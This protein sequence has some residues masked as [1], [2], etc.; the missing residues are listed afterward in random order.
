LVDMLE[1]GDVDAAATELE[2]HLENAEASML[3]ALRLP[4]AT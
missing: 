1:R 3:T 4:P 2:H